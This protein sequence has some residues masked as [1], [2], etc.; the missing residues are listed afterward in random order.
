MT[1]HRSRSSI[2]GIVCTGL[3]CSDLMGQNR[4]LG[5]N[6][7]KMVTSG[8]G[9]EVGAEVDLNTG[10]WEEEWASVESHDGQVRGNSRSGTYGRHLWVGPGEYGK[11]VFVQ[12]REKEISFSSSSSGAP[13]HRSS[14]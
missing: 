9:G 5:A 1:T 6:T 4:L 13:C 3:L 12:E 8:H 10:L 2:V 11:H 14:Q 7:E